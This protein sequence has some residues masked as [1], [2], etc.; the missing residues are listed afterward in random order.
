[1][2]GRQ[3]VACPSQL[4]PSSRSARPVPQVP[5]SS[6]LPA[7]KW[8][9]Q[10]AAAVYAVGREERLNSDMEGMLWKIARHAACRVR[11]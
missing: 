8:A 11:R 6:F 2:A 3:E 4:G 9:G 10:V 7:E 5:P 1:M